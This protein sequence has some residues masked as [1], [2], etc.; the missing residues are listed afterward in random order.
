MDRKSS[1]R[2][3]HSSRD[4]SPPRRNRRDD[5]SPDRHREGRRGRDSR[6]EV[7]P[8]HR[9]RNAR[10]DASPPR[11][12]RFPTSTKTSGPDGH[13][14]K[15]LEA[16]QEE[17]SKYAWGKAEEVNKDDDDDADKEKPKAKKVK[18]NFEKSGKLKAESNK[19]ADG[20]VLKF[21]DPPE[22]KRPQMK[23][24]LYPFKGDQAL[25]TAYRTPEDLLWFA[26]RN[27]ICMPFSSVDTTETIPVYRQTSYLFG[28]DRAV[29]WR[30]SPVSAPHTF[31]SH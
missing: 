4:R 25:G 13:K 11:R 6:S 2:D 1:R 24:R 10:S 8:P 3:E 18:P 17:E 12:E 15:S 19:T 23:W 22:A 21:V 28:R 26:E 9:G 31:P 20:V 27:L 7:S 14:R 29:R 16:E 5:E 30:A